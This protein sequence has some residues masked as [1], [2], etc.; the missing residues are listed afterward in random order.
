MLTVGAYLPAYHGDFIWDDARH[1]SA[2][3]LLRDGDGLQRLWFDIGATPQYYPLTYST[4]WLEWHVWGNAVFGYHVINVVL[5]IAASLMLVRLLKM[6]DVPGAWLAGFVF[7]LHPLHV[8]SVAWISERKNTLSITFMLAALMVYLKPAPAMT[9]KRWAA[10]FGLFLCA[11]FSKTVA[12]AVPAIL[13]ILLVWKNGRPRWRDVWPLL[14]MFA[15]A[16]AAG[17]LTGW[18]ERKVVG[19]EGADWSLP[20]VQKFVVADRAIWWYAWKIVWPSALAF[21]YG[22]WDVAASPL[23]AWAYAAATFVFAAC[24]WISRR[25]LGGGLI[26]AGMIFGATLFPALGF[27]NLYPHRFSFVADHFQYYAD[28]AAIAALSAGA[29][30]LG[31]RLP[32]WAGHVWAVLLVVVLGATSFAQARI[33]ENYE[34]V[35]IDTIAKNPASWIAYDNL[36]VSIESTRNDRASLEKAVGY[37]QTLARLQPEHDYVHVALGDAYRKLGRPAESQREFDSAVD[38]LRAQIAQRPQASGPYYRLAGAYDVMNRPAEATDAWI[39][40]SNVQPDAASIVQQV[41]SHLRDQKRYAEALPWAER[42]VAMRPN[43]SD[44]HVNAAFLYG[45]AGRVMD[46]RHELQAAAAIDPDNPD[47]KRGFDLV[48]QSLLRR[49]ATTSATGG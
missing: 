44:P 5:H 7:A 40:A 31:A 46:A 29:M 4:F 26:A 35:W 49:S 34:T 1:V 36:G 16:I 25:W 3:T 33:Y 47:V 38:H 21:N 13:L 10:A 39:A 32:K 28:A 6:L 18:M 11:V 45:I 43:K 20:L 17:M 24:V 23:L 12:G 42:W 9:A 41:V 19:A 8:E 22:R 2:N 27:F 14:P 30:T 37:L 15:V 48:N